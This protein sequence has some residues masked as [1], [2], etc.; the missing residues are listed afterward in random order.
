MKKLIKLL[1]I[2]IVAVSLQSC[3][4]TKVVTN[5]VTKP[6][7]INCNNFKCE[8]TKQTCLNGLYLFL[9]IGGILGTYVFVNKEN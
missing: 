1:L 8:Q 3:V 4:S 5:V 2:A 7:K 9:G 6:T